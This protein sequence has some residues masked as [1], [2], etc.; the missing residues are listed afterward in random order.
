MNS[1]SNAHW[2]SVARRAGRDA[3]IFIAAFAIANYVRFEGFWRV[4]EFITPALAG[5]LGL[6]VTAY[7]F[8]LYSLESRGRS[9]F[10]GHV[11]LLL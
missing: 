7:I 2:F 10:V 4:D 1:L 8:G 3:A 11:F 6:V 9:R 5:M